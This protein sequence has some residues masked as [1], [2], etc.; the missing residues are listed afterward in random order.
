MSDTLTIGDLPPLPPLPAHTDIEV[1]AMADGEGLRME[2]KPREQSGSSRKMIWIALLSVSLAIVST[3]AG[4]WFCQQE[5]WFLMVLSGVF[6]L[7]MFTLGLTLL[8]V[9]TILSGCSATITLNDQSLRIEEK[10]LEHK[11]ACVYGVSEVR[12]L[13]VGNNPLTNLSFTRRT[14]GRP[15]YHVTRKD[16]PE[17]HISLANQ[18][19]ALLTACW[20]DEDL[21]WIADVVTRRWRL[22]DRM[23]SSRTEVVRRDIDR[24]AD[25]K[26]KVGLSHPYLQG[27]LYLM[28]AGIAVWLGLM[29][30][31]GLQST[32]WPG[33]EAEFLEVRWEE[34]GHVAQARYTYSVD[35]ERYESDR[36][37][38]GYY[39]ES[40]KVR[41][42]LAGRV[43]GDRTTA[44][45]DPDEPARAVLV[46][47][48]HWLEWLMVGGG[49]FVFPV[50]LHGT[51]TYGKYRRL[52]EAQARLCNRSAG[53][54]AP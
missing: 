45:Y 30:P 31:Y 34:D 23:L 3:G 47:G 6:A 53:D 50:A 44:F 52:A 9:C 16:K 15:G 29:L 54:P 12:G 43:V 33:A 48:V 17:L 4:V 39:S 51:L 49:L 25:L 14:Q 35:G 32:G 1:S 27:F 28:T 19:D 11:Q 22:P 42:A 37:S 41:S 40:D 36:V 13:A 8:C 21:Q 24:L 38:Y 20:S 10:L 18:T 7:S 26:Q 5:S 2:L 46:P